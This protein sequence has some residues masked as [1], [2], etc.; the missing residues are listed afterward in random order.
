MQR[1]MN[2]ARAWYELGVKQQEN[3]RE[4]RALQALE[5]AVELD[6]IPQTLTILA[7]AYERTGDEQ[8]ALDLRER[9]AKI[10]IPQGQ[11]TRVRQPRRVDM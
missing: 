9:A 3:E 2:N 11:Q 6:P 10:I 7:E 1:D 4:D 8:V 5:R